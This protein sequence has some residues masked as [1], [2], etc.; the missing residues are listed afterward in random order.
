MFSDSDFYTRS[1]IIYTNLIIDM[2]K[3]TDYIPITEYILHKKRRGR[4]KLISKSDE[5]TKELVGGVINVS[6]LKLNKCSHIVPTGSIVSITYKKRI[7]GIIFTKRKSTS[8]F[9]NSVS[10]VMLLKQDDAMKKISCK[11]SKYG[12]IHMTGCKTSE[13]YFEVFQQLYKLLLLSEKATGEKIFQ[14]ADGDTHPYAIFNKKMEN[15]SFNIGFSIYREKLDTYLN[16]Y[17]DFTSL[18]NASINTSVLVKL[19]NN[20]NYAELEKLELLEGGN[21]RKLTMI[22]RDEFLGMITERDKTREMTKKKYST[23]MV[24]NSG[25]IIYSSCG[26]DMY[27]VYKTFLDFVK[28]HRSDLEEH[29]Y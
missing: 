9:R 2:N 1:I 25:S 24:F 6:H 11:I 4:R 5:E 13:H 15:V 26:P 22:S 28:K 8:S 3:F 12:K 17:T 20:S 21:K 29:I 10:F 27:K 14:L 16:D 7:R 18:Y 19:P 23:F